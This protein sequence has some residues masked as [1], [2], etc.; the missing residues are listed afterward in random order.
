LLDNKMKCE[1]MGINGRRRA[2]EL[3]DIRMVVDSHIKIYSD[4]L[5]NI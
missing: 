1:K 5:K 2:E 4:L 3:F